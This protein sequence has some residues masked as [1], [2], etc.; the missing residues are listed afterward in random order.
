MDLFGHNILDFPDDNET[1]FSGRLPRIS[2]SEYFQDLGLDDFVN[3]KVKEADD[4]E[5]SNDSAVFSEDFVASDDASSEV[6]SSND[7]PREDDLDILNDD[8]DS[9]LC[10][11]VAFN[12][13]CR[14]D[15]SKVIKDSASEIHDINDTVTS[16]QKDNV[17]T[18]ENTV[19]ITEDANLITSEDNVG[20]D[21]INLDDSG[22]LSSGSSQ[23][24]SSSEIVVGED[25]LSS[26]DLLNT[27]L[28]PDLLNYESNT[29]IQGVDPE[30]PLNFENILYNDG[31]EHH[32]D[33]TTDVVS[34]LNDVLQ[35]SVSCT[36]EKSKITFEN[37]I[38][39]AEEDIF[40]DLGQQQSIGKSI[41]I[42]DELADSIKGE[43][44]DN[45]YS[46]D[47]FDF[48]LCNDLEKIENL[49][50]ASG[51]AKEEAASKN[52]NDFLSSMFGIDDDDVID[53]TT[54]YEDLLNS[55]LIEENIDP[56][57]FNNCNDDF[58][59]DSVD[60]SCNGYFDTDEEE[61]TSIKEELVDPTEDIPQLVVNVKKEPEEEE[62][63]T[64]D[65][66][67]MREHDYSL[68]MSSSL[69]LTPPHSPGDDFGDDVRKKSQLVKKPRSHI[70]K[71]NQP[72]KDLKFTMTLP[73][74]KRSGPRMQPKI[75]SRSL[76]KKKILHS[77]PNTRPLHKSKN[78]NNNS[79]RDQPRTAK[80][81]VRE[82]LEKRNLAQHIQ[83]KREFVRNMK[84]RMREE[85]QK[86]R[87]DLSGIRSKYT[88]IDD[89]RSKADKNK[90][91][92]F[93]EERELHNSM[94]R[95][96]RIEMKDA[97]DCLKAVIPSIA[98]VD[99]VSKLNILNTARD[100]YRALEGRIERLK[101]AK[102]LEAERK[103]QLLEKLNLLQLETCML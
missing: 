55:I 17:T 32:I 24:S 69:F 94:E 3:N 50:Q 35:D 90:Y 8:E 25:L 98:T 40:D 41:N 19:P 33:I 22:F 59:I 84:K 34:D 85:T 36:G 53:D 78:P 72:T 83:E 54:D 62:T 77:N 93:E 39:G 4:D 64:N 88:C 43:T 58:D 31:P 70:V 37:L 100:Y 28:V 23:T 60:P 9:Y 5:R 74:K 12:E 86:E 16:P 95:Q 1:L 27:S 92:K 10:S 57:I 81:L 30:V 101:T 79:Q 18:F 46:L 47:Q 63:T 7:D 56:E 91:R 75:N 73:V 51:N 99:K 65:Y 49:D 71:F 14:T 103:R 44:D 82:I 45:I 29:N 80:E 96:R 48:N 68:P 11:A 66:Y 21:V 2:E 61:K 20:D 97:Y 102:Q 67:W 15:L 13:I 38:G 87:E 6:P 26:A 76:L 52:L 89:L 42:K